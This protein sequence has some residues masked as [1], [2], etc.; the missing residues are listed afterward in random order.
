MLSSIQIK[1]FTTIMLLTGV[2]G[3][4]PAIGNRLSVPS[5][6][7]NKMISHN[8]QVVTQ[9]SN[10]KFRLSAT[11]VSG[12]AAEEKSY[13][14]A[15]DLT[16]F[17]LA[18]IKGGL[19]PYL[20][21]FLMTEHNISPSSIGL[22]LSVAGFA[23]L[24]CQPL[25]G[26]FVDRTG[27]P[28]E[29]IALACLLVTTSCLAVP[30]VSGVPVHMI[31]QAIAGAAI[32]VFGPAMAAMT[33][34]ITGSGA[35][36]SKRIGRNE[37]CSH[38]GS[39]VFALAIGF[40]STINNRSVFWLMAL[41]AFCTLS[42]VRFVPAAAAKKE[43]KKTSTDDKTESRKS[44]LL[45]LL[46]SKNNPLLLFGLC[47]ALFHLANAAMLPLVGQ[48]LAAVHG[49]EYATMLT[50]GAIVGAQLVMAPVSRLVGSKADSWGRRPLLLM[51]FLALPIR[52][53]LL[54]LSSNMYW[55]LSVQL[56]DGLGVGIL[57]TLLPLIVRDIVGGSGDASSFGVSLGAIATMQGIGA[58]V[59]NSLA[60]VVVEYAGFDVAFRVLGGIATCALLLLL[61]KMPET[62]NI[63]AEE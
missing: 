62:K 44:G 22:I 58:T 47:L 12:G 10:E 3:F 53:F 61:G 45:R 28:R 39:A 2:A 15:M 25:A 46:G 56:L 50:S 21:I 4:K 20:S 59:S 51:G 13:N 24:T 40:F 36:F 48:K 27:R 18:D 7:N 17:F 16:S 52:G 57:D 32:G 42:T 35:E 60:G 5:V 43:V 1:F 41:S 6:K 11:A 14:R 63:V 55:M 34:G 30:F 8:L 23:S 26:A 29:V 33:L 31:L 9:E 19:G 49:L 38:L 37:M 54:S